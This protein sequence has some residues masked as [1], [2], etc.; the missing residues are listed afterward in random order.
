M[1]IRGKSL[2]ASGQI[3]F[4]RF[5]EVLFSFNNHS[6]KLVNRKHFCMPWLEIY[7]FMADC[8]ILFMKV[9]LFFEP[10]SKL[11]YE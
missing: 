8:N 7:V 1:R 2:E 4:E 9:K 3:S 10:V 6:A 11:M 5:S